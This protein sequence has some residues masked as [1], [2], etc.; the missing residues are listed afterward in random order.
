[1]DIEDKGNANR[2]QKQARL[3]FVAAPQRI[4]PGL[5]IAATPAED[6]RLIDAKS[7]LR[8]AS[9]FAQSRKQ[10]CEIAMYTPNPAAGSRVPDGEGAV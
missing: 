10:G 2:I 3:Y 6:D 7:L 8:A 1:M 9:H 5:Q 4:P